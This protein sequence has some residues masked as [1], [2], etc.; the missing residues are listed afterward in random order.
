M[1]FDETLA[2][3]AHENQV[4]KLAHRGHSLAQWVAIFS[5]LLATT[6]ALVSYNASTRLN[7]ILIVKNEA[8]L[9]KEEA[10]NQW[11]YFQAESIK[12]HIAQLALT[13]VPAGQ[14]LN[15]ESEIAKYTVEK[16]AI[17]KKAENLDKLS[18]EQQ[19]VGDEL[20]K[21]VHRFE[22]AQTLLQIAIALASITALTRRLWLF[23]IAGVAA[24]AALGIG[25]LAFL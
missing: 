17:R 10:S 5:A 25:L 11:N 9:K 12:Q 16:S 14:K 23:A 3:S 19:H 1:E 21:H 20:F 18:A 22:Q 6:A 7:E 13:L 2:R 24:A 8:L 4:E 15:Y